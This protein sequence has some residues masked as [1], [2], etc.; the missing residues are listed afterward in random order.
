MGGILADQD[1]ASDEQEVSKGSWVWWSL[2]VISALRRQL[3][4]DYEVKASQSFLMRLQIKNKK[5][6]RK[7]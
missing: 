5:H 7:W 4:K 3:Q 6:E 1:V 2:P